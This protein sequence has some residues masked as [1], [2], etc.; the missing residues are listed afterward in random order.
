MLVGYSI[1]TALNPP[2]DLGS[3]RKLDPFMVMSS[4]NFPG[5]RTNDP[6]DSHT[7]CLAYDCKRPAIYT[8]RQIHD[9]GAF[10]AGRFSLLQFFESPECQQLIAKGKVQRRGVVPFLGRSGWMTIC[11][12]LITVRISRSLRI[13]SRSVSREP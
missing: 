9:E 13:I 12:C 1:T 5:G 2:C 3:A 7:N 4:A 6:S 11:R 10:D 8:Y